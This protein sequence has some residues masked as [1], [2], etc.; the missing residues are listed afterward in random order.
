MRR[1]LILTGQ[2]RGEIGDL[3]WSEIDL[4]KRQ[5]DLPAHRT[6]NARPHIV[7]LSDEALSILKGIVRED[8]RDLVFGRGAGGFG[9]WGKAKTEL[10]AQIAKARA[11]A[12]HKAQG[13]PMAGWTLHDLRRSFVTHVSEHGLAQPHVVEAIVNHVSGYKGGVAGVY[14]R[15]AYAGEKRQALELWGAHVAALVLGRKSNVVAMRA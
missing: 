13:K 2:R 3:S 7:P 12:A 14:N 4:D 5:I 15:A 8:G 1:L 9:G 10:C 11:R 6:K